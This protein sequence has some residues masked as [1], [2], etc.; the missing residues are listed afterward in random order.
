MATQKQFNVGIV[1]YGLSAKVFHIPFIAL[2]PS[3]KLH[4]IV[5]RSPSP[6]SNS[7]PEDHPSPAVKHHTSLEPLLADADVHVVVLCTP[8]NTHYGFA[9]AALEAGKHVLVEKPF[10]PTSAE[11]DAL[12]AL[13]RE[14]GRVLCVYQNRRWD[15]DFLTV[16][17]LMEEGVLGRVVEFE[18]HFDRLR[19]NPPAAASLTWKASMGMDQGGGPLYDL[20]THLLDQVF[21]L[22]GMPSAVYG[23][24]VRQREGRLVKGSSDDEPD[25]VTAV[26]SYADTGLVVQVRI[27]V[28]SVETRQM[29]FW[30]RG[31]KGSYHKTGLD[32]QEDQLRAGGKATD[33]RFGREDEEKYGFVCLLRDDGTVERKVCPTVEPE[34]Y[35]KFYE[36]FAKAVESGKEEDVPVPATQAAQVLR[37]IEAVRESAKTGREVSL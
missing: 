24:F 35:V 14:R 1:G 18:T 23:K 19:P 15:S 34:T 20:G 29:R 16:R 30:V 7:A 36:L 8:P 11:A 28:V 22:F 10:V 12:A 3:L 9:R 17:R 4:S 5:Q 2:T 13:A 21:V 27:G 33:A 32:P 25:S 6:G 26:L 31:S 37:I